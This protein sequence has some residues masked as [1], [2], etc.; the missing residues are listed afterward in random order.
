VVKVFQTVSL[1]TPSSSDQA[2]ITNIEN[3]FKQS[4]YDLK[5]V[6]QQSAAVCAGS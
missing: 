2:T 5:Q 6:F 4:N 1:R 3:I